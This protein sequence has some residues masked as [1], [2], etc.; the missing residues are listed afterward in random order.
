MAD[1]YAAIM[2][3]PLHQQ[4]DADII[5]AQLIEAEYLYRNN[6]KMLTAVKEC[7]SSDIR[8]L[9]VISSAP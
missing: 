5:L 1:R 2:E 8:P 6:R 7:K 4:P 3:L 9:S